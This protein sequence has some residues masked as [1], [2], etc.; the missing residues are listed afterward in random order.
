M[1]DNQKTIISYIDF[2]KRYPREHKYFSLDEGRKFI[3]DGNRIKML[4]T[5][6][7]KHYTK[8]EFFVSIDP[9][10]KK[11]IFY[12]FDLES[13]GSKNK[14]NEDMGYFE[15]DRVVDQ[16]Y[17]FLSL[18]LKEL[19]TA[20]TPYTDIVE[21]NKQSSNS[22]SSEW[23]PPTTTPSQPYNS[24]GYGSYANS[25]Y[26]YNSSSYK[27]REAFC[28]KITDLLKENHTSNAI[29]HI[30]TTIIK[31]C[32]DKKFDDIDSVL[33]WITFD[34]LNIP[35]MLTLLSATRGADHLLKERKD[36]FGKVR[37]HIIKIKPTK[38]EYILRNLEPGKEYKDVVKYEAA[39]K[40]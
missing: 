27:E 32:E 9:D 5:E 39:E 14:I 13:I 30:S 35:T 34:K 3:V 2:I 37:N 28:S 4:P 29:D 15:W 25:G 6:Y 33:R 26:N 36:F 17:T 21:K 38:A 22:S 16:I 11:V 10:N 23:K 24:N 7:A 12:A 20:T 40:K 8:N 1:D 18:H 19:T 31:M